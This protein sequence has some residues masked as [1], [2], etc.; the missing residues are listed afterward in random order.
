MTWLIFIL[1][2][3]CAGFIQGLTGFAFALIAM[4]FWVWILPPQ[5]AAPL[6]VSASVYSHFIS[7]SYEKN[8]INLDRKLIWPYLIAGLIGVPLGTYLLD[9][10][11]QLCTR[12]K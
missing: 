4:S 1:G 11:N 10:I 2:A 6:V 12:Q 3:V 5:I 7:L 8:S 9:I